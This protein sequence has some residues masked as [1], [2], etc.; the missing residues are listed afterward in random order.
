MNDGLQVFIALK[1]S[2]SGCYAMARIDGAADGLPRTYAGVVATRTEAIE[3][4]T[5]WALGW[6]ERLKAEH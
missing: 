5:G 2:S 3:Q 1:S 6:L 4:A